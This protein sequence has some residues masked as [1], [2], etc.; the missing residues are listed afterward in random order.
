MAHTLQLY[1]AVEATTLDIGQTG[2]TGYHLISYS[3]VM[4]AYA[5]QRN[6]SLYTPG[7]FSVMGKY[8]NIV[9]TITAEIVG[10]SRDDL[11]AKLRALYRF[12]ENARDII[13]TP[14]N[15]AYSYIAYKP[16]STTSTG[17]STVLGGRVDVPGIDATVVTGSGGEAELLSNVMTGIVITLEREPFWRGAYPDRTYSNA[18]SANGT[19]SSP[20]GMLTSTN[21]YGDLPATFAWKWYDK[22]G[23]LTSKFWLGLSSR[24]RKGTAYN[25]AGL[26]EI[27]SGTA[28]TDTSFANDTTASPGGAGNTKATCTFGTTATDAERVTITV[29]PGFGAFRVFA[30]C[31][32][33]AAGTVSLYVKAGS[34][35]KPLMSKVSNAPVTVTNTGNWKIYDLGVVYL[36]TI[37]TLTFP[38]ISSN[39]LLTLSAARSAGACS[40]DVDYLFLMPMDEGLVQ[41]NGAVLVSLKSLITYSNM[42]PNQPQ[43]YTTEDDYMEATAMHQWSGDI[44]PPVGDFALYWLG[45]DSSSANVFTAAGNNYPYYLYYWN[46]YISP[47]GL[48]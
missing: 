47:P 17:Y 14:N 28:G 7:D 21:A 22:N 32:L 24:R 18:T 9:E 43:S 12:I 45:C 46:I 20:W 25:A 44:R 6:S 13:Q 1:D 41:I 38:E 23:T 36:P 37:Q 2:A 5:E 8:G 40:L 15:R 29:A 27:E 19:T 33:S 39:R 16:D 42:L 10:T 48:N 26:K 3:P 11:F 30:R 4:S 35:S 31:Q 34:S